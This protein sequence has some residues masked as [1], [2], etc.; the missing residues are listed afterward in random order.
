MIRTRSGVMK[1]AQP[2]QHTTSMFMA[3]T[4]L[5]PGDVVLCD[6]G[7][8]TVSAVVLEGSR[9]RVA[10]GDE[11]VVLTADDV[12]EVVPVRKLLGASWSLGG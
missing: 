6:D 3:G 5:L 4:E 1:R 12:V 8:R 9:A 10:F 7:E 2:T 11:E